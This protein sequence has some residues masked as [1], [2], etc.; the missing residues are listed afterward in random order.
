VTSHMSER[1]ERA[2]EVVKLFY[3]GGARGDITS[4]AD[5]LDESFELAVPPYLPWGGEFDKAQYLAL[6]PEVA[7]TLDFA[8]M[9]Y[10]S[11]TAEG[12]HVVALIDIPV[13]HTDERIIISEHW[14][15]SEGNKA[16]R[17]LVAYFDARP[18]LKNAKDSV[19]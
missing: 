6:L 15:I 19:R 14:D 18:L 5:H 4:F 8:R 7:A 16:T 9:K 12:G 2:R 11:L 3:A 1:T 10:A 13:Q 17:L